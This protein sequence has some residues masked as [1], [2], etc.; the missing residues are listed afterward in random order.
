MKTIMISTAVLTILLSSLSSLAKVENM[1][2]LIQQGQHE[3]AVAYRNLERYFG[4]DHSVKVARQ[5]DADSRVPVD[6]SVVR[7]RLISRK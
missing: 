5:L 2:S 6:D 3:Q 4:F 7:I 1:N